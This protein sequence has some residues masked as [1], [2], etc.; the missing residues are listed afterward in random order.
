MLEGVQANFQNPFWMFDVSKFPF[1]NSVI[2][3]IKFLRSFA[4]E[5][6]EKRCLAL[7]N[8]EDTPKDV[9]EHIVKEA[10]ENPDLDIDD[11]VDNFVT[12]FVAGIERLLLNNFCLIGM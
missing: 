7:K 12:V 3:A 6:I 4:A 9:L 2:K 10:N 8:G 5:V 11:L 1:Q